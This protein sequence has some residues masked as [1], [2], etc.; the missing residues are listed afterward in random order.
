MTSDLGTLTG[1][2]SPQMPPDIFEAFQAV[3][4]RCFTYQ[5]DV[6]YFLLIII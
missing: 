4:A 1:F 2:V 6:C 5:T 3:N